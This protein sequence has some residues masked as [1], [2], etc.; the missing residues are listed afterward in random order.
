MRR[1]DKTGFSLATD[2][3]KKNAA[4]LETLTVKIISV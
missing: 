3:A 2:C 4:L 1:L